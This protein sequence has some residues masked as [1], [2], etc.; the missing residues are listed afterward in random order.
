MRHRR[1]GSSSRMDG[2][3]RPSLHELSEYGLEFTTDY[4]DS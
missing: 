4:G 3:G 2:R 1:G